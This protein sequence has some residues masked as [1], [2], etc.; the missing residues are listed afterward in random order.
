M[1]HSYSN[2]HTMILPF[3]W[4]TVLSVCSLSLSTILQ[5][6]GLMPSG[7]G[8]LRILNVPVSISELSLDLRAACHS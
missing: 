7:G 8:P 4:A 3:F 1:P 2:P 5:D 6:H